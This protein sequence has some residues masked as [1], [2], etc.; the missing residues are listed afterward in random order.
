MGSDLTPMQEPA[1]EAPDDLDMT[2]LVLDAVRVLGCTSRSEVSRRLGIGRAAVAQRVAELLAAGLIEE[3]GS[4]RST[5]GRPPRQLRFR[6]EAGHIL[7]ADLG[8]TSIDVAAADLSARILV[9]RSEAADVAAG[10]EVILDRVEALF[11]EVTAAPPP[12]G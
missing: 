8:A 3:S 10:P 6:A 7:A 1:V 9:H 4:G 5:G 12:G 11:D 2:R